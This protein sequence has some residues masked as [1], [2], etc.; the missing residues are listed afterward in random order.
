MFTP[1]GDRME[2]NGCYHLLPSTIGVLIFVSSILT[3]V[4]ESHL[5]SIEGP[6]PISIPMVIIVGSLSR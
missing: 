3:L 1:I 2:K 4:S 6:L 5:N